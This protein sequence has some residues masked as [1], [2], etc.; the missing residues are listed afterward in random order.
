MRLAHSARVQP[1]SCWC[2]RPNRDVEMLF[3][4]ENERRYDNTRGEEV[5]HVVACTACLVVSP[6]ATCSKRAGKQVPAHNPRYIVRLKAIIR[7]CVWL[8][9]PQNT[10]INALSQTCVSNASRS[11]RRPDATSESSRS[12]ASTFNDPKN[13]RK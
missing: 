11:S 12:N 10:T 9:V 8:A 13:R 5:T 7:G 4:D 6:R 3:G 1:A 2:S